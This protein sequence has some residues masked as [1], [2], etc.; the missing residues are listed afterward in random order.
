MNTIGLLIF[1]SVVLL[2][3]ILMIIALVD[4]YKREATHGPKWIWALVIILGVLF[5]PI[6][7][8][9]FGRKE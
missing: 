6:V 9:L 5:G 2:Q 4:L 8:F 1:I 3:L 7:Y